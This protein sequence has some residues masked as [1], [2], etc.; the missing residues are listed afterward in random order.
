MSSFKNTL[1]NKIQ[2][3]PKILKILM[4]NIYVNN[5]RTGE[6]PQILLTRYYTRHMLSLSLSIVILHCI[7]LNKTTQVSKSLLS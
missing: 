5:I 3:S 2:C 4:V 6:H 1:K 7:T